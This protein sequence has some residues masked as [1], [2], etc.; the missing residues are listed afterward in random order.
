MYATAI[1]NCVVDLVAVSPF[2][3]L[4]RMVL[5]PTVIK[6]ILG[7]EMR[8]AVERLQHELKPL[9]AV[10]AVAMAKAKFMNVVR[11]TH[12]ED[13]RDDWEPH[14]DYDTGVTCYYNPKL[15]RSTWDVVIPIDA[16]MALP[17]DQSRVAD[18]QDALESESSVASLK[19]RTSEA[20]FRERQSTDADGWE[21]FTDDATGNEYY[22][23]KQLRRTTW[24]NP[25]TVS[26]DIIDDGALDDG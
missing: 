7:G 12:N 17:D 20:D 5:V 9:A 19:V 26:S 3:L 21:R 11:S 25:T 2:L 13:S 18:D 24:S 23:N 4:I 6:I 15:R 8:K 1:L 16:G 14:V 10:L 22:V